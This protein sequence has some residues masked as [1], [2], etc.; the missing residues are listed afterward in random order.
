MQDLF[1]PPQPPFTWNGWEATP[2]FETESALADYV[3]TRLAGSFKVDREVRGQHCTGKWLRID[4]VLTPLE[5]A[6]WLDGWNTALAVEFKLLPDSY[7]GLNS[8]TKWFAQCIDYA[9]TDWFGYG[10][11]PI[12]S[13]PT[14]PFRNGIIKHAL[15]QFRVGELSNTTS[16]GWSFIINGEHRQWS[17]AKGIE[18]ARRT[19]L[20]PVVGSR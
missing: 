14:F 17:E 1:D 6:E 9:H 18:D 13:C 2:E 10:R 19:R 3:L 4:A 5:A 8:Y 12:F 15:G 20:R 11:L 16:H 7:R